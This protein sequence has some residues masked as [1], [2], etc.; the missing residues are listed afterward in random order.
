MRLCPKCGSYHFNKIN[1][2]IV[3]CEKCKSLYI[4]GVLPDIKEFFNKL[5]EMRCCSICLN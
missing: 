1:N 3:R 4:I 2:D 5:E